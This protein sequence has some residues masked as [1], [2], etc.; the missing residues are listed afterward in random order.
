MWNEIDILQRENEQ[1]RLQNRTGSLDWLL[2]NA[3]HEWL[4]SPVT[5]L[6]SSSYGSP[7]YSSS[8]ADFSGNQSFDNSWLMPRN[9]SF[10]FDAVA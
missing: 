9:L 7:F 10:E 8:L 1:L 6:T 4:M 3:N 2:P 5:S